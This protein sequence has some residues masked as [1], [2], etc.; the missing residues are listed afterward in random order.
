M[1]PFKKNI[2]KA[3][4][5]ILINTDKPITAHPIQSST[6]NSNLRLGNFFTITGLLTSAI[7]SINI[8]LGQR[9][10]NIYKKNPRFALSNLGFLIYL[11]SADKACLVSTMRN[12]IGII[13]TVRCSVHNRQGMP[14]LYYTQ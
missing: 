10:S 12:N 13:Y 7:T 11:I 3:Q 6:P 9:G 1:K 14:C 5:R 8:I 4:P 2:L